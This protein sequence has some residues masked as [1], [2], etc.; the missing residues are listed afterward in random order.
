[1]IPF[2]SVSDFYGSQE[3]LIPRYYGSY[4]IFWIL[5]IT[6]NAILPIINLILLGSSEGQG[7]S[8][9][10]KRPAKWTPEMPFYM[11]PQQQNPAMQIP[12]DF[13]YAMRTG[14]SMG[15]PKTAPYV[16]TP[17]IAIPQP[18]FRNNDSIN[19]PVSNSMMAPPPYSEDPQAPSRTHI[20]EKIV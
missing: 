9:R 13:N 8:P 7:L 4:A 3:G 15:D 18:P 1:M 14:A 17:S 11:V 19:V 10:E 6:N 20:F 16:V 5:I 12:M 2:I